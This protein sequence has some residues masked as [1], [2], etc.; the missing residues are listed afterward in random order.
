MLRN[1]PRILGVI[2]QSMPQLTPLMARLILCE[3]D[4]G[5]R[6]NTLTRWRS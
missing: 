2:A 3:K 5:A 1:H 6:Q 4:F